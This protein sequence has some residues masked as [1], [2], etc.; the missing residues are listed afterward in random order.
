MEQQSET[1][2]FVEEVTTDQDGYRSEIPPI[3]FK[4]SE[5]KYN[6]AFLGNINSRAGLFG[7]E[8]PRGYY[9][10]VLLVRDN[11]INN[12]YLTIN[13]DKRVLYSELDSFLFKFF[14]SEQSGYTENL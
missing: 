12:Q 4:K 2:F 8:L 14:I 13:N 11:T 10:S 3:K 7:G 5:R 6:G 9:I 1:F